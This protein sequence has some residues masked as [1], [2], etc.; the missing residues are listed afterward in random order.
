MG[1]EN[2]P[3]AGTWWGVVS[4]IV[5]K[6]LNLVVDVNAM[7]WERQN[8]PTCEWKKAAGCNPFNSICLP[9]HKQPV[10]RAA[11]CTSTLFRWHTV[12]IRT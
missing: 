5:S 8:S 12:A 1:E 6:K 3:T 4:R 9:T 11:N 7:V 2:V 10:R